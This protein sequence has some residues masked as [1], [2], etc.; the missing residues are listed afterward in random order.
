[1]GKDM[2]TVGNYNDKIQRKIR[3]G[4][5]ANLAQNDILAKSSEVTKEE[6]K[7]KTNAYFELLTEL[8]DEVIGD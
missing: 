4:Q 6:F 3:L 7:R 8:Y 5:A 1:M 2:K